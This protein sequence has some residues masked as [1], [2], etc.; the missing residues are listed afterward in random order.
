VAFTILN[1][2]LP[3]P[4]TIMTSVTHPPKAIT[5]PEKFISYQPSLKTPMTMSRKEDK[6]PLRLRGGCIPCCVRGSSLCFLLLSK[7]NLYRMDVAVAFRAVDN[8]SKEI[9]KS[10]ISAFPHSGLILYHSVVPPDFPIVTLL[11]IVLR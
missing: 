7:L 8:S 2:A 9:S 1:S 10:F 6:G 4:S 5:S 11:I 3:L